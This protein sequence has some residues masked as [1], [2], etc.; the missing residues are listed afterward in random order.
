MSDEILRLL[1]NDPN[2]LIISM[3]YGYRVILVNGHKTVLHK[4]FGQTDTIRYIGVGEDDSKVLDLILDD[5][6]K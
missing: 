4:D 3:K 6:T 1:C 5:I 2:P